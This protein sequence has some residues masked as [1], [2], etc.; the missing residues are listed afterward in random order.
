MWERTLTVNGFSKTFAMTGCRL[1]YLAGPKHFVA[2]CGKIQSQVTSS[3][4]NISQKVGVAALGI[5]VQWRGSSC[6]NGKSI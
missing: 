3:A 4:S 1:E 2:A 6:Q 5:G